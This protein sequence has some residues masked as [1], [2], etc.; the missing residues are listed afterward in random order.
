M[1]EISIP[2]DRTGHLGPLFLSIGKP[3][4]R[5]S[6]QPATVNPA[7]GIETQI[8]ALDE[9]I[10]NLLNC[11]SDDTPVTYGDDRVDDAATQRPASRASVRLRALGE[12]L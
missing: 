2:N 8:A 1:S 10:A 7:D 9:W 11:A 6:D 3:R 5:V 4:N 12:R